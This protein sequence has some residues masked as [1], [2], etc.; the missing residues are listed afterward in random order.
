M[1]EENSY[2]SS[3]SPPVSPV[4]TAWCNNNPIKKDAEYYEAERSKF[5]DS[6]KDNEFITIPR[7][8]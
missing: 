3:I 5:E 2:N 7:I 6:F 4:K 8:F 1:A